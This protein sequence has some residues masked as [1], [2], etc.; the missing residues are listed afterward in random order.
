MTLNRTTNI[1]VII[2]VVPTV[3]KNDT[4]R[5]RLLKA[6]AAAAAEV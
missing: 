6:T 1:S 4:R 2:T 3:V 5:H